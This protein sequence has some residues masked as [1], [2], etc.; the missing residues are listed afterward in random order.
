LH[1]FEAARRSLEDEGLLLERDHLA[2]DD[3]PE[4]GFVLIRGRAQIL[5]Y[6][7]LRNIAENVDK[8]DDFFN[9]SE[10]SAQKKKR[11]TS[12]ANRTIRESRV[13]MDTFFR[14]AM[15]VKIT[16]PQ[17]C[18]F[19]GPLSREHLRE[20]IRDMIYK[21]GSRSESERT[22]LA[23]VSRIPLVED[24]IEEAIMQQLVEEGGSVSNQLDQVITMLNTFQEFLGSA[25]YSDIA[26]SPIAVYREVGARAA[27]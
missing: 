1:A 5:D 18:S 4:D 2:R 14:E 10:T 25:S 23:E 26:M 7:T 13:V 9:P 15:R 8:L 20:N 3:V 24:S 16:N 27:D 19:I 12:E 21:Y 6:E 17:G 11:K 22:M